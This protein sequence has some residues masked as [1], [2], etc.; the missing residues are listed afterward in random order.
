MAE[1]ILAFFIIGAVIGG[2]V[3]A[4]LGESVKKTGAGF[5]LG[6][7]LG[8][9]GWIIVL[10]LPRE[11]SNSPQIPSPTPTPTPTPTQTQKSKERPPRDLTSNNYKIWLGKKYEI[12]R[13]ELFDQFECDGELFQ[14]LDDALKYADELEAKAVEAEVE[15]DVSEMTFPVIQE[16]LRKKKIRATMPILKGGFYIVDQEG[17][18]HRFEYISQLREYYRKVLDL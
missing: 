17:K 14:S 3:G 18:E 4:F 12:N 1:D 16:E 5:W 10:L 6:L 8:P 13:N 2:I 9:I 11:T 15:K 7:F